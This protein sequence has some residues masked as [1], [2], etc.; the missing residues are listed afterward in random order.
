MARRPKIDALPAG[1]KTQLE[2]L[3]L[4]KTHGGYVLLSAWLKAQG[5][6]ISHAAVH[7]YDQRLQNVMSRI[8]ASTEAARLIAQAAPDDKLR[9]GYL[10]ITDATALLVAHAKGFYQDEGLDVEAWS[11]DGIPECVRGKGEGFVVGVQ[12]HPE[13]HDHRFPELLPG[14]PLLMSFMQAARE[15]GQALAA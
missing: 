9:I 5:F 7:R 11:E 4:D 15:R 3:L 13:F 8:K 2:R 12:W 6:E 14:R 1:L 10:P